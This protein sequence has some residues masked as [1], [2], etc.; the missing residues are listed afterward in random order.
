MFNGYSGYNWLVETNVASKISVHLEKKIY[1]QRFP[2][3]PEASYLSMETIEKWMVIMIIVYPRLLEDD[4][5]REQWRTLMSNRYAFPL[6]RDVIEKLHDLMSAAF[7]SV[8]NFSAKDF[9]TNNFLPTMANDFSPT[10]SGL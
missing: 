7:S 1:A 8:N 2:F 4:A 9:V 5:I 6:F 10:I 3:Q